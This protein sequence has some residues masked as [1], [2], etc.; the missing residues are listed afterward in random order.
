MLQLL[1]DSLVFLVAIL[2]FICSSQVGHLSS[3]PQQCRDI[4]PM[5]HQG[6]LQYNRYAVNVLCSRGILYEEGSLVRRARRFL[7][8]CEVFSASSIRSHL[9]RGRGGFGFV[10]NDNSTRAG[11]VVAR[12]ETALG[13]S[14]ARWE[15]FC[16][17]PHDGIC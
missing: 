5:L 4:V 9:V 10:D 14:G 3:N 15:G 12:R 7:A 17:G 2:C 16:P 11:P 1:D 8:A 6:A 13:P